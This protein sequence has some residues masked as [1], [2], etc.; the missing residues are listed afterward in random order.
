SGQIEPFAL[1]AQD[2]PERFQVPH[3]LYGRDVE[4]ERLFGAF[5]RMAATGQ[6]ALATVSGYSGIGKSALVDA[7]RKPIFARRGYFIAGKFDQYQRDVPYATLTQAFRE[8][9]QQLLTESEARIAGWRQQ[10]QAAVGVNGQL[11]VDVLPQV[12]L[13]IGPQQP[14]PALPPTEAQNRFRMVFRQFVTVF[15]SVDHPLVLFLDD[16][17]WID[18]ASLALIGHLLTHPDTRYLLLIGAYRDNEVNAGH[19]LL[20]VVD[21]IRRSGVPVIDVL[22]AP[23]TVVHLNL[24]VADTLHASPDIYEPLTRMVCARTQG[25]P[26]FFIQ[27]LDALHKEGLLRRDAQGRGWQWDLAQIEARDFADNVVDL[28][29]GKLRQLPSAAQQ[30]LQLAACLG[31]TFYLRHLALAGGHRADA[32]PQRA[33]TAESEA[34]AEAGLAAAVR[35]SLV[36][37]NDGAGKFLHD[38][39]QQAAYSLIPEA[40]RDAVHLSIGRLLLASL[41]EDELAEHVFDVANQFNRGAGLLVERDE[42][43]QVAALDLRAGHRA[44]LSAAYASACVYLSAGMALLDDS[45]WGRHYPLMFSLW[46]ERAECAFLTGDFARAEQ[47]IDEL[48]RRGAS[49]LDVAAVYERKVLLHIVKSENARAVDHALTCLRLF[50]IDFP[51]HPTRPQVEAEY[52][53]VWR[54]LGEQPIESLIDLPLM[55]DPELLAAM[56]VMSSSLEAAYVTDVQLFCLLLCRMVNISVHYGTNGNCAHAYGFLGFTL[57]PVFQRY[58]DGYRFARLGHELAEKHR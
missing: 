30:A 40:Q 7:L 57:G 41:T 31:N 34:E 10:I 51:A 49:K 24:L 53:M 47:L 16:L 42:K 12:E 20:A 28:M 15:T 44:K 45:D 56:R 48:L 17:Q 5:E 11:I 37:C 58:R 38:R 43:A 33:N 50:G 1:G 13:I 26:F 39:I 46:L 55:T 36:V 29:V 9:V 32:P 19:P 3:R 14:V 6:A 8:L 52:D 54:N 23:L 21:T 25:N 4:V 18:A 27:F 2:I 22:L 35:A